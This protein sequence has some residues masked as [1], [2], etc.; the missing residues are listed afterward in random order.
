MGTTTVS[1]RQRGRLGATRAVVALVATGML[2]SACSGED[3]QSSTP[4]S[5]TTQMGTA[6]AEAKAAEAAA[7]LPLDDIYFTKPTD[8]PAGSLIK[9]E[10]FDGWTLGTGQT[11]TRIVYNSRSAQGKP[12]V[13]SA[14]VITPAGTPP[15]NGWPVIAWAHGTTG[16]AR[17]CAPSLSKDF[18]AYG[19][20]LTQIAEQGYAIVATDYSGLGAGEDHEYV[21]TKANAN[22]VS[23]SVAAA[24]EAVPQLSKQWIAAGHSQGGQAAWGVGKQQSET[25]IGGFLGTVALAPGLPLDQLLAAGFDTP[26]AGLYVPFLVNSITSQYPSISP[27]DLLTE[28]GNRVYAAATKD[29]CF[30]FSAAV[31]DNAAPAALMQADWADHPEVRT[32]IERNGYTDRRLAGPAFVA[33][34]T[35]DQTIHPE[36]VERTARTQC[37][38]ATPVL[39]R[40]F[41]GGHDEMLASSAPEVLHWVQ[42]RFA[43]VQPAPSTC[44]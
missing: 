39:Y 23:F 19:P 1:Y 42:D 17:Q 7:A 22:D 36:D 11:G 6:V 43:G 35:E 31:T 33:A 28:E 5:A 32:F 27:A 10:S 41:P 13:A 24:R 21:T 38:H 12:N 16:V 4:V 15:P 9:A 20:Y 29:G 3:T 26:G 44:R 25:P 18:A 30:A 40:S 14:A 2:I 8:G 37:D 34:G